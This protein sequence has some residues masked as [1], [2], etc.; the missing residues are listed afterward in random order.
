MG[1]R[2]NSRSGFRRIEVRRSRS[3]QSSGPRYQD[4]DALAPITSSFESWR[5][6][7]DRLD[8]AEPSLES[9]RGNDA[10]VASE[11]AAR[12]LK[13]RRVTRLSASYPSFAR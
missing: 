4:V 5:R 1:S 7:R 8:R 2:M 9:T 11:P 6:V 3:H 10:S 12:P 13:R